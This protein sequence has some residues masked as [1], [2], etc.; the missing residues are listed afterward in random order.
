MFSSAGAVSTPQTCSPL[1]PQIL[2]ISK[3]NT[4]SKS[5]HIDADGIYFA[6]YSSKRKFTFFV[7]S[8]LTPLGEKHLLSVTD[9]LLDMEKLHI[10]NLGVVLGLKQTKVKTLKDSDTF[11][12]DVITAW[13]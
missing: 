9:Y 2:P 6:T 11:L 10:Y 7:H 5:S 3:D 8:I 12:D 4:L 13:L 1:L